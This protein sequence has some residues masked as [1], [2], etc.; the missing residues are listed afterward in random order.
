MAKFFK[1][2]AAAGAWACF[3][4]FNRVGLEVLSVVTQQILTIQ[5]AIAA[6]V[7]RFIFEGT[8]LTIDPA[9][10]IF[11]TMNSGY[12]SRSELPNNLK[13][14]FRTVAMMVPGEPHA[15]LRGTRASRPL[16]ATWAHPLLCHLS[17]Q[18]M[19]SSA[20]SA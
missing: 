6:G 5:R 19:R 16:N 20:R 17:V 18:T 8:D 11:I 15:P 7:Q 9:N 3:D 13:L 12:A 10:A 1:G 4:E 14:L 2:V